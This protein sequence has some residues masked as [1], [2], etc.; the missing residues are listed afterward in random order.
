MSSS[1]MN[2]YD[3]LA[4]DYHR[5][6]AD[7]KQSVH[8]QAE[9]LGKL[10]SVQ[11]GNP[12]LALLDCTCGIG[13]Q[14]IGLAL[15][16]YTVFGTDLSPEAIER[17]R[18]EAANFGAEVMFNVADV[19]QL[20]VQVSGTFDVVLSCDNALAHFLTDD[21]LQLALGNIASKLAPDGLLVASIRDYDALLQ[22]KPRTTFPQVSDTDEN[23]AISFQVWDWL[24]NGHTYVLN[25]FIVKQAETGW[26]TTCNVTKLRAWRR[27]EVQLML[28]R[29]GLRDIE[30]HM[31]ADSDYYQPVVT[32][33][34]STQG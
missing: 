16:G 23:R 26:E 28:A 11:K 13:T 10:I 15:Q 4:R 12:P 19:L 21:Q 33:R 30:W 8:R 34:K 5:I 17:A 20:E 32:A 6:F 3:Q 2:F 29:A 7:W 1:A 9:V 31:P 14:A 22:E 18:R 27:A 24:G 25:H